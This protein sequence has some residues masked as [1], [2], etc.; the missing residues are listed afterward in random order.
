MFQYILKD[1]SGVLYVDTDILFM[2]PI[3][4]VWQFFKRFNSTQIAALTPEH[5]SPNAGWYNRFA[6]HPYYGKLGRR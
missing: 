1:V 3:E 6:R 5:E 4:N 2:R